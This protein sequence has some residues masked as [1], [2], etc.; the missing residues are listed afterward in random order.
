ME[1]RGEFEAIEGNLCCCVKKRRSKGRHLK[2]PIETMENSP[3]RDL[4]TKLYM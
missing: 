2:H 1:E 3:S 4:V